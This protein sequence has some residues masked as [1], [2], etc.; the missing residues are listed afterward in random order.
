[1]LVLK[2][3]KKANK[4]TIFPLIGLRNKYFLSFSDKLLHSVGALEFHSSNRQESAQ[5]EEI[6][7]KDGGT[8]GSE[9]LRIHH[10]GS[11]AGIAHP[12]RAQAIKT[13]YSRLSGIPANSINLQTNS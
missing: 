10:M 9:S 12:D 2:T 1:M 4:N 6:R 11:P 5:R 7:G 13:Y 8:G 3:E